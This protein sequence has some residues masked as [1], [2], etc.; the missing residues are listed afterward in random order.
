[1]YAYTIRNR[2]VFTLTYYDFHC[3]INYVFG[4]NRLNHDLPCKSIIHPL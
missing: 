4:S 3:A 2:L 1:L